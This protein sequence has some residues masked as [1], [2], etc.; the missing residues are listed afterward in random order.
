MVPLVQGSS[1]VGMLCFGRR[2]DNGYPVSA[3]TDEEITYGIR[4]AMDFTPVIQML[5][6]ADRLQ[7]ALKALRSS[8]KDD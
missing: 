4:C 3:F 8:R 5:L 6:V 2:A 1:W 7:Q